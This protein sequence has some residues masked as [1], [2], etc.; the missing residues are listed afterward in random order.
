MPGCKFSVP[1]RVTPL[2]KENILENGKPSPYLIRCSTNAIKNMVDRL[3]ITANIPRLY[4][5]LLRHTFATYYL[6]SGGDPITLQNILGHESLDMTRKYV[7][8]A[9]AQSLKK[10]NRYSPLAAKNI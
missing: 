3:K 6:A 2:R 8:L 5:H 9:L 10:G 4:S 7:H 1:G